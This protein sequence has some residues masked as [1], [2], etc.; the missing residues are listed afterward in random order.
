MSNTLEAGKKKVDHRKELEGRKFRFEVKSAE[1]AVVLI[2]ERLGETANVISVKQLEGKGLGKL[3][4]SP[5][6]EIVAE[7]PVLRDP[8][9]ETKVEEISATPQSPDSIAMSNRDT[10]EATAKEEKEP[11]TSRQDEVS[12]SQQSEFSQD[13]VPDIDIAPRSVNMPSIENNPY[14]NSHSAS[15]QGRRNMIESFLLNAGFTLDF[16]NVVKNDAV[17]RQLENQ[18][19]R[20]GLATLYH[21]MR[22][23][24][25]QRNIEP[26]SQ[27]IAFVG[28]PGT[29]KTSALCRF[30]SHQVFHQ[31]IETQVL[32]VD[33][34]NPNPDDELA[35]FCDIMGTPLLRNT[36]QLGELRSDSRLL[37]DTAGI[38]L[39]Q[40][41]E[42]EDLCSELDTHGV[43]TKV[44][45][46]NAAYDMDLIKKAFSNAA[47]LGITHFALSHLD[48]VTN[49]NKLWSLVLFHKCTPLLAN[50]GQ[51][52]TNEYSLDVF[53][54]LMGKAFPRDVMG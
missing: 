16:I 12:A 37:L 35:I 13:A 21:W 10:E 36:S 39:D 46:I 41:Q 20:Q 15:N 7:V 48:E 30:L 17:W 47:R 51:S 32:K 1:E 44:L 2:R 50:Y 52:I 19:T 26:L 27:R 33:S 6:L 5:K 22:D 53:D 40:E 14:I 11:I 42:W 43:W 9:S 18:N 31:K 24:Y 4:S 28:T 34:S 54:Y 49:T 23:T 38:S 25:R 3:L 29:G 8:P 45:V